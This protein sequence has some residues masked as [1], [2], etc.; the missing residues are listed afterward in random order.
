[1]NI[2]KKKS[3][4]IKRG[5]LDK[6]NMFNQEILFIAENYNSTKNVISEISHLILV[7]NNN[8]IWHR[9]DKSIKFK[10]KKTFRLGFIMI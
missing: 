3:N 6:C 2:A 10:Q 9:I 8:E 4:N 1:L 7:V 5:Y